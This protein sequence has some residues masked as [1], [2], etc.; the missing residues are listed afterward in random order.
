MPANS[1]GK[2]RRISRIRM[3]RRRRVMGMGMGLIHI[4]ENEYPRSW[5]VHEKC[6][7][8]ARSV[9]AERAKREWRARQKGVERAKREWNATDANPAFAP[10]SPPN[11]SLTLGKTAAW[12]WI[13]DQ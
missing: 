1:G 3:I 4:R 2:R 9:V 11:V 13:Q 6:Q 7:G 8:C 12:G 5:P 10:D